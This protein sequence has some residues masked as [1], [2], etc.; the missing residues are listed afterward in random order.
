MKYTLTRMAKSLEND[1]TKYWPGCGTIRTLI[2]F[3]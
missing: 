1:I 2:Y 3:W